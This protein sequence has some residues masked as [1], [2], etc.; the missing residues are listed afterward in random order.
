ML[1]PSPQLK[2]KLC[3]GQARFYSSGEGAGI[4]VIQKIRP[5]LEGYCRNLYPSQFE[6]QEMIGSIVGKF[7]KLER[8]IRS[9]LSS[10]ISTN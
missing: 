6:E 8:L 2:K 9:T 1:L 4:D 5:V 7:V 3:R 10:R